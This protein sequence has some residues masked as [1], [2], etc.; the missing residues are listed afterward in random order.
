MLAAPEGYVRTFVDYGPPMQELLQQAAERG[1]F[2]EYV[3]SLLAVFP[4]PASPSTLA[5]PLTDREASILRLMAAGLSHNEIAD[6]LY[7]SANTIK[8]YS[9]R[10]YRKLGVR[11]R[12]QA[13][14]RAQDL[15][16]L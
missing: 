8:W 6:E 9:T 16:L 3:S 1:L 4:E 11:R 12:S 10:I 15:G 7:L 13:V 5:E 2:S 14:A